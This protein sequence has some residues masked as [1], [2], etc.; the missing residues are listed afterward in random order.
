MSLEMAVSH[1][2]EDPQDQGEFI[3]VALSNA[4][5]L[6]SLISDMILLSN[7]DQNDLN[8]VRQSIDVAA[9]IVNPVQKRLKRYE[10]RQLT[11][12]HDIDLKTAI[13]APRREFTQALVHLADNAFKLSPDRGRVELTVRSSGNGGALIVLLD[14]GPGIPAAMREKVF[15][16][17]YQVSQGTDREHQG[18]GVG[19]PIARAVFSSL[20]GDVRIADSPKGCRVEA[21]LPDLRPEDVTFN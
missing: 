4:D 7:I 12:V 18:L 16:H 8:N 3:R 6:E 9:H 1:K 20:G 10:E 11:F 14:E 21:I 15:E 13:M 5:R 19:L 17:F 2:Y